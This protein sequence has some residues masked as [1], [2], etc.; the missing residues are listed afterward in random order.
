MDNLL[1]WYTVVLFW[2]YGFYWKNGTS[3]INMKGMG[4]YNPQGAV[5]A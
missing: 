5:A 4:F 3:F 1:A 2:R